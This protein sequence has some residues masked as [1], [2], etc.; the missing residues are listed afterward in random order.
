MGEGA[1]NLGDMAYSA[2]SWIIP[3]IVAIVFHE[4]AHGYVANMLGDSTA[5]RLGRLTLNPLKHVDPVGTVALPL[6]LAVLQA[7]MFGWAKPVP[8]RS[9]RLR[10]PR[11]DMALV[12][13]AGPLANLFMALLGAGALALLLNYARIDAQATGWQFV[14]ANLINF[15]RINAFLAVFNMLP[16]PPFDGG[17]VV[18][19]LLPPRLARQYAVLDRYGLPLLLLLIVGLPAL[20]PEL[21]IIGRTV[22][23]AAQAIESFFLWSAGLMG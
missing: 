16:I 7:P 10:N 4:V 22:A 17:H 11:L 19:G 15:L 3:L 1:A 21:D 5:A 6:L 20:S 9:D 12:A 14:Y 13:I 8:V 2:L 23:P 18:K